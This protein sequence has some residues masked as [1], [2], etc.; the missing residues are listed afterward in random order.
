VLSFIALLCV[1]A[2]GASD[3]TLAWVKVVRIVLVVFLVFYIRSRFRFGQ[4]EAKESDDKVEIQPYL[5]IL[6]VIALLNVFIGLLQ[7]WSE[8]STGMDF[9][10]ESQISIANSGV[11]K[12]IFAGTLFVRAYGFFPHPNVLAAFFYCCSFLFAATLIRS[13]FRSDAQLL[14]T[15]NNSSK[16]GRGEEP[17]VTLFH[18]EQ[19]EILSSVLAILIILMGILATF[20]RSS[21]IAMAI[22]ILYT[23]GSVLL[24]KVPFFLMMSLFGIAVISLSGGVQSL[25]ERGW[26]VDIAIKIMSEHPVLG[27][28]PG[29]FVVSM[30]DYSASHL[31]EWQLQP[32]HNVFQLLW[33]ESGSIALILFIILFLFMF[34]VEQGKGKRTRQTEQRRSMCQADWL[35]AL[36]NG[37]LLGVLFLLFFD[38]YYWD[39]VPGM[40]LFGFSLGVTQLLRSSV[41]VPRTPHA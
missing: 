40:Y 3:A 18:V 13:V 26:Y 36:M 38:H 8:S 23:L 27:I 24:K 17:W 22:M 32:V 11:A 31:R 15:R 12:G 20:S 5:A 30:R 33:A 28:G 16:D 7:V 6:F 4:A 2:F 41:D 10:R 25:H 39:L 14:S 9:L 19:L 37:Y 29:N 21:L 34:H 35:R 1:S